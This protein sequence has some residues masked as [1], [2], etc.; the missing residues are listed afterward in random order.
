MAENRKRKRIILLLS[1]GLAV[2]VVVILVTR[3]K[4]PVVPVV[5]VTREDL[6][7]T[8]TSNG[9]VEPVSPVIARAEFATFVSKVTAT[10]GA[11]VRRGHV[12]LALDAAEVSAQL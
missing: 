9:K 11:A 2:L 6:N 10:E 1:A 7:E 4:D 12:I 3:R 5:K 8:I